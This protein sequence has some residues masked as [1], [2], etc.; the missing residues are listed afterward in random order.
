MEQYDVLIATPGLKIEAS[1]VK[2]LVE[3]LEECDKRN[4]SYKWLNGYSSLVHHARELTASGGDG[5]NLNPNDKGPLGDKVKY[6]KMFWIDSDISWTVDQFF[7]LYD[8]EEDIM[9]GAYILSDG[10]TSSI[11]SHNSNS[12][13]TKKEILSISKKEKIQSCGFGFIAIKY[14]VFEKIERP[15]FSMYQQPIQK[16]NGDVIYDSVGEDV[17]WCA[18]AY[19]AGIDIYLDPTVLVNHT[20]TIPITW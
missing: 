8:A 20:K 13:M 12:A 4:I 18:K 17:S 5:K 11:S 7:K 19:K 1:Y 6:K 15:W 16:N 14:G 2:S 3:T 10:N 9:T